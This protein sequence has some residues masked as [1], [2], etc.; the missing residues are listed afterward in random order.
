MFGTRKVVRGIQGRAV[1]IARRAGRRSPR[2]SLQHRALEHQPAACTTTTAAG[3]L[4]P[5]SSSSTGR[6]AYSTTAPA[7]RAAVVNG[8][9]VPGTEDIV[10]ERFL[11]CVEKGDANAAMAHFAF[12]SCDARER[13]AQERA[14]REELVALRRRQLL[15]LLCEKGMVNEASELLAN[16]VVSPAF[17]SRDSST[18]APL[19]ARIDRAL[20]HFRQASERGICLPLPVCE[21]LALALFVKGLRGEATEMEAWNVLEY[22]RQ[23]DM[24]PRPAVYEAVLL[25]ALGSGDLSFALR[26]CQ[27]VDDEGLVLDPHVQDTLFRTVEYVM[28]ELPGAAA[29]SVSAAPPPV[30]GGAVAAGVRGDAAANGGGGEG[31]WKVEGTNAT[32]G[33]LRALDALLQSWLEAEMGEFDDV[34]DDDDDDDFEDGEEI[35]EFDITVEGSDEG[36]GAADLD[37]DDDADAA[38]WDSDVVDYDGG[39]LSTMS[40]HDV[41]H[42]AEDVVDFHDDDDDDDDDIDNLGGGGGGAR[43]GGEKA[44]ARGPSSTSQSS[45]RIAWTGQH[46]GRDTDDYG[47]PSRPQS[48][49]STAP[50]FGGEKYCGDLTDQVSEFI[51]FK[52]EG[53]DYHFPDA[54]GRR[55]GGVRSR[56]ERSERHRS[57]DRQSVYADLVMPYGGPHGEGG[58]GIV[59]IPVKFSVQESQD[60]DEDDD[61][62][63]GRGIS[64]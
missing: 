37:D 2:R 55:R 12:V 31:E 23:R 13:G 32:M 5:G 1:V 45:S 18:I 57:L 11:A 24:V 7:E 58:Q 21:D 41:G 59:S 60:D 38:E 48:S 16:A 42:I 54:R 8:K 10:H 35:Q 52:G 47:D 34:E 62:G 40:V 51:P 43:G 22:V 64:S 19:D 25:C 50:D 3:V 61:G 53:E 33:E 28:K 49:L 4:L 44:S 63:G 36:D 29:V 6:A 15:E 46:P 20:L 9:V 26:V 39:D 27:H 17:N 56:Q 14:L 30:D